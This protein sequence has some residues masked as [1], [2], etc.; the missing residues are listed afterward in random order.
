MVDKLLTISQFA[1]RSGTSTSALRYYERRGLIS[2]TRTSGN[3][4]RY[5]RSQLRRVAFIRTAQTVGLTLEEVVEALA[6]LPEERTP[7]KADWAKLS[8]HWHDR[9]SSRIQ[10]MERLR[11]DLSGCIGCGCLSL[12][13]CRLSNRDDELA[14]TGNGPRILLSS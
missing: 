8:R 2:S 11:D 4:R 3:Q 10:L 6:E 9:L 7:S 12:T 1:E 13:A 5:Q 14:T